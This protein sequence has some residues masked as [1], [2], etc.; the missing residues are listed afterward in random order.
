MWLLLLPLILSVPDDIEDRVRAAVF[1]KEEAIGYTREQLAYFPSPC[2]MP[3]FNEWIEDLFGFDEKARTLGDR[4]SGAREAAL[5]VREAW[6]AGGY[7]I[8]D[9]DEAE[10]GAP[11]LDDLPPEL[12]GPVARFLAV[13]PACTA[14]WNE[15]IELVDIEEESFETQAL[16]YFDDA[17]KTLA[18]LERWFDRE[19]AGLAAVLFIDAVERLAAELGALKI[20][21]RQEEFRVDTPHGQV[22]LG[23]KGRTEHGAEPPL[24]LIDVSG[25]D[26]YLPG[27]AFGRGSRPFVAVID[28]RGKDVYLSSR[29]LAGCGAGIG[30]IGVIVDLSGDDEYLADS[31]GAGFAMFG[32]GV[33]HDKRGN[34]RYV[35]DELCQAVGLCGVGMILDEKGDDRYELFYRG[36]GFGMPRGAGLLVDLEGDDTYL[37]RDDELKNPSPQTAEHNAS[38]AQ[39]VGCGVRDDENKVYIAGGLGLLVDHAG[40][41]LYKGAVF[42]QAIGY[43]YGVGM[44]FDLS[45]NDR[46]EA[47]YY[48]QSASAHF[49]LSYLHDREGNDDYKTSLS[50]SLGNGRDLSISVFRDEQGN[51]CY[52]APDRSLGCGD[53]N[54]TGLFIDAGGKDAYTFHTKING[55][56][57]IVQGELSELRQPF[58]TVGVFL[59]LGGDK[60][61]YGRDGLKN[62]DQWTSGGQHEAIKGVGID[63]GPGGKR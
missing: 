50:Q 35:G 4:F 31:L 56:L 23:A 47:V 8:Y 43:W 11:A 55:G 61:E 25:N 30:G 45:G 57:G 10:T 22:V 5:L 16:R 17:G 27:S 62:G 34:D 39:G 59:D 9:P 24:L 18:L 33:I 37:A 1:G 29:E 53:L 42:A 41:D 21:P 52:F 19:A 46:Y 48:G 3:V 51:D 32:A 14:A 58:P 38:M 63:D 44:L 36:Q 54:G 26:R 49:A 13:M 12:A 7:E 15:A 2:R 40:D 60:D 6:L 20:S 28:L